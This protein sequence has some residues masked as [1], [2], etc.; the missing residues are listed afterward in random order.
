MS[1]PTQ[2]KLAE[3]NDASSLQATDT[4]PISQS[5]GTRKVSLAGLQSYIGGTILTPGT[6]YNATVV[7]GPTGKITSVTGGTNPATI[8]GASASL[9]FGTIEPLGTKQLYINV[10]GADIGDVAVWTTIT[11]LSPLLVINSS[12]HAENSV[13]IWIY[14]SSATTPITIAPAT[15]TV[16]IIK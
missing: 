9:D 6:Y 1:T 11:G 15:W 14:N 8:L 16:R 13:A 10:V 3:L 5:A 12:V 7:V 4:L 2:I